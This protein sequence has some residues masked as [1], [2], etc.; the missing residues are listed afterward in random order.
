MRNL[1]QEVLFSA[2]DLICPVFVQENLKERNVV[3]SMPDIIRLPLEDLTGDEIGR[4][5][6]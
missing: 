4:A 5:H 6:V 3:K 2:N 1:V